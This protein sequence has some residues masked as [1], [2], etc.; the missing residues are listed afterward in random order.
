MQQ[1][2]PSQNVYTCISSGF[3]HLLPNHTRCLHAFQ[4][5]RHLESGHGLSS[6]AAC[7]YRWGSWSPWL[8]ALIW[9]ALGSPCG[10]S[11]F[12]NSLAPWAKDMRARSGPQ[13]RLIR[14]LDLDPL[15]LHGTAL[16]LLDPGS[17]QKAASYRHFH[18]HLATTDAQWPLK[19]MGI[20]FL[21]GWLQRGTL[22]KKRKN[23]QAPLG[24]CA[25][26]WS[27]NRG[28]LS[29]CL[30]LRVATKPLSWSIRQPV[31]LSACEK[32]NGYSGWR[33]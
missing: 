11:K 22:P 25:S 3:Y 29:V 8:F 9:Y 30:T 12:L 21:V 24:N 33:H 16:L 28:P 32:K 4:A 14:C 18:K 26:T 7:S 13:G 15:S 10:S 31:A 19:E 27:E 6:I 23:G 5:R 2:Q 1:I 20:R 17:S